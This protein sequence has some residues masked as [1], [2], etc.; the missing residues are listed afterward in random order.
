MIFLNFDY[1]KNKRILIQHVKDVSFKSQWLGNSVASLPRANEV[2][3]VISTP[4]SRL[5][6]AA[7]LFIC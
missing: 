5:H 1:C 3:H 2:D 6:E 7:Y 4:S